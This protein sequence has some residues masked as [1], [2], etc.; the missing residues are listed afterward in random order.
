MMFQEQNEALARRQDVLDSLEEPFYSIKEAAK[1]LK[2][3]PQDVRAMIAAGKLDTIERGKK[4]E[5]YI[6]KAELAR[7]LAPAPFD[8]LRNRSRWQSG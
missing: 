7:T 3:R 2:R 4:R 5:T 6:T 1:I 8:F